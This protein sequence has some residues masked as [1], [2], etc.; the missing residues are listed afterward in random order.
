VVKRKSPE[1]D[2][3]VAIVSALNDHCPFLFW[4]TPNGG[5][6]HIATAARLKKEGVRPGIPDIQ[7]MLPNRSA[8]LELKAKRGRLTDSQIAFRQ[9][10]QATGHWWEVANSFEDA[11]AVLER[12]GCLPK[13]KF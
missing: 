1:R 6:R 4:H 9:K 5:K 2:L 7:I 3:Q 10:A 8:F 11:W 12:W 13:A